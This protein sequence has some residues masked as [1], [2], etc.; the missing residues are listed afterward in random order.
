MQVVIN[1]DDE[2]FDQLFGDEV[3]KL[4]PREIKE[5]FAECIKAYFEQNNYQNIE[6]LITEKDG[7]YYSSKPKFTWFGQKLIEHCDYS[8]LQEVVDKVIDSMVNNHETL[9]KEMLFEVIA[10]GFTNS[11]SMQEAFKNSI[12]PLTMDMENIKTYLKD[13]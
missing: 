4:D 9:L 6:R 11:Y 13:N 10:R 3:G 5:I 8:K 2:K 7:S 1:M 12:L